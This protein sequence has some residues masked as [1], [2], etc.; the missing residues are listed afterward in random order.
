MRPDNVSRARERGSGG[1]ELAVAFGSVLLV[2]F[3]VVG[4]LRVSTTR[5]DVSAAARAAARAASQT[6]S[7]PEAH[8]EATA[9]AE[10]VLAGRGV[11][12]RG[13]DVTLGRDHRPGAIVIVTVTCTVDLGDVVLVGFPGTDT[14][15]A[16]AAE[17]SDVVRG[18]G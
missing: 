14:V 13:L 18:G 9:V 17:M 15:R 1:V 3:F 4:A 8:A 10:D 11:A 16:T 7:A 6:Y 12:C 2:L 5:G